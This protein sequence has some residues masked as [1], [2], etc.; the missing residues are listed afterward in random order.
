ME[1]GRIHLN[2]PER[3]MFHSLGEV[4]QTA[5]GQSYP[6]ILEAKLNHATERFGVILVGSKKAED[7][8]GIVVRMMGRPV[9]RL[10]VSNTLDVARAFDHVAVHECNRATNVQGQPIVRQMLGSWSRDDI[11]VVITHCRF[12]SLLP[13]NTLLMPLGG[14]CAAG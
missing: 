12:L 5:F 3:A 13:S 11:L 2:N 8:I 9:K 1:N 14:G 4:D 10:V 7:L 6:L